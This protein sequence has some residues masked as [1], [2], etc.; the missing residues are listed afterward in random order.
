MTTRAKSQ[1][2]SGSEDEVIDPR[3]VVEAFGGCDPQVCADINMRLTDITVIATSDVQPVGKGTV[4]LDHRDEI[5]KRVKDILKDKW[6]DDFDWKRVSDVACGK[7]CAC[8]KLVEEVLH[9]DGTG[10]ASSYTSDVTVYVDAEGKIDK[11]GKPFD[12]GSPNISCWVLYRVTLLFEWY[13]HLGICRP[14]VQSKWL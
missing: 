1:Q 6:K 10:K 14:G 3:L 11:D 7:T 8:V 13:G 2:S 9:K 4:W 12:S 5:T